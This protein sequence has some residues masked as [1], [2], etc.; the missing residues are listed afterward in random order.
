MCCFGGSHHVNLL[1]VFRLSL[2]VQLVLHVVLQVQYVLEVN[3]CPHVHCRHPH[4]AL[5][6]YFHL[7][8]VF[9]YAFK[10]FMCQACSVGNSLVS[11]S[12]ITLGFGPVQ[13]TVPT[14][15]LLSHWIFF[16]MFH[17]VVIHS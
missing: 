3:A 6:S 7:L 13:Y 9:K 12:E 2:L 5:G 16:L 4:F 14:D 1:Y 17:C 15:M 10:C 11:S 8:P